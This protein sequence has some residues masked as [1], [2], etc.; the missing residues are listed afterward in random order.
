MVNTPV[1][2]GITGAHSTGK[3]QLMRRI[4]MELRALGVTVARTG[5]LGRRAAEIG[6]P[7][8]H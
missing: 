7:K 2:I 8:M 3:T 5:R 1:R 6:L 4:E